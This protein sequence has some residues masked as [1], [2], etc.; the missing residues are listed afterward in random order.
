MLLAHF[1]LSDQLCRIFEHSGPII[2]LPQG[3]ACQCSSSDV[4]ATYTFVY[5]PKYIVG[6]CP[7]Y[8]LEDGC[9]KTTFIEGPPINGKPGR[10]CPKLRRLLRVAWQCSFHQIVPYGVHPARLRHDRGD[11]LSIDVY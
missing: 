6:I 7:S 4:V 10:S 5:F 9:G 8:T 2:S 1:A 11:F 3:F